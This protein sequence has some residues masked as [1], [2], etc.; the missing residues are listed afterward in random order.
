MSHTSVTHKRKEKQQK[1]AP[2]TGT[3]QLRKNLGDSS[4]SSL[5]MNSQPLP[6][7]KKKFGFQFQRDDE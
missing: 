2:D 5:G 1:D 7:M 4:R 3:P 6:E